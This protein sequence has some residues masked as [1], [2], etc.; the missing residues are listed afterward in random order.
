MGRIF[1][2][3]KLLLTS[4]YFVLDG[5]LAL[6]IPTKPGQEFFFEEIH[7]RNSEIIWQAYHQE[8]LWLS[9]KI[10]YRNWTILDTNM[11]TPAKFVVS[12]LQHVQDLSNIRFHKE[13]SYFLKT[14]L[15]FPPDFGL[16][17]S[18]TLM[19]NLAEWAE[20]D[21]F[22]LNGLALGGSGYD[23]AVAQEKS[24]ILYQTLP[25]N[26]IMRIEF[27]PGFKNELIFIHL[28]QK[29]DSRD[30][31]A[32]YRS[33]PRNNELIH[34]LSEITKAV[35]LAKTIDELTLYMNRHELL[36][37]S[38]L[39]IETAKEK[40]FPQYGGFIKS[41]GAWGGDFVLA[42]KFGDYKKYF[43]DRNF[44][45]IFEWRDLVL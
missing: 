4:E 31:I 24:P 13:N 15:Q 38:F 17:S 41:L 3:G 36:I 42:S 26:K 7:D 6:A 23:I 5:A 1:S 2:P 43:S 16:G 20:I 27:D 35:F 39:G 25:E 44:T 18:S 29:Q 32:L 40:Y 22:L 33:K 12:V 21:P 34:E 9:I 45:R 37:S 19:N 14:N 8:K 30:G 11:E 10:N 28:N